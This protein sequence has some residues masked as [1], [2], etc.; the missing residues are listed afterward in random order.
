MPR[1]IVGRGGK[2]RRPSENPEYPSFFLTGRG[3]SSCSQSYTFLPDATVVYNRGA[4]ASRLHWN[5]M[6]RGHVAKTVV[7]PPAA[8]T[9]TSVRRR[10]RCT[11]KTSVYNRRTDRHEISAD[12]NCAGK[13]IVGWFF[14]TNFI[15][16]ILLGKIKDRSN[17]SNCIPVLYYDLLLNYYQY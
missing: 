10:T 17:S 4:R 6:Y 13:R 14:K 15:S 1:G 16:E 3:L 11:R 7:R 2:H 12:L 9:V 5:N 8:A